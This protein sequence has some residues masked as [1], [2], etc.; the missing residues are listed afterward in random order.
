[1][2]I[3]KE[4]K[5]FALKGNLMDMAVGIIIGA[6]IGKVVASLVSD[7]LLP[8]I[9][10]LLGKVNFSD[11]FIALDGKV[12]AS[13][14]AAKTLGAPVLAYGSFIQT[15]ID[16]LI[17]AFS[18]FMMIKAMNRLRL[19]QAETPPAPPPTEPNAQ[20]KLLTEIRDLLKKQ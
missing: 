6:A 8:P 16:F 1:M 7:V 10:M 15:V 12:Y 5:E 13:V 20:E 18:I 19:K 3:G 14:A 4:F 9:G 17:V 11:L 2:S